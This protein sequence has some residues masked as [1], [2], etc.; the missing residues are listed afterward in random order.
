[1]VSIGRSREC[2]IRSTTKSVS[3]RHAEIRYENGTCEVVDL[4]SSNG[5][6]LIVDGE[7]QPVL[8]QE[9]LSHE[10]EVWCGEF[11]VYYYADSQGG[12]P[13]GESDERREVASRPAEERE[14]LRER[15]AEL[16][17]QLREVRRDREEAREAVSELEA[18]L[19]NAHQR[20]GELRDEVESVERL[21]DLLREREETIESLEGEIE[22]LEGQRGGEGGGGG[23]AGAEFVE[24]VREHTVP[25]YRMVDAIERTDLDELSTVDRIRLESA[26]R[27]TEPAEH[28]EAVL[29]LVGADPNEIEFDLDEA[30]S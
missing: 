29:E 3:R 16:E 10:D 30:E 25:L 13:R 15:V 9:E 11:I 28:L 18:Q 19:E 8:T 22:R 24:S 26:I 21:E 14:A 1:V 7:R 17:E 6:Y 4:G 12:E 27:A 5:T 20:N 23:G 2:T